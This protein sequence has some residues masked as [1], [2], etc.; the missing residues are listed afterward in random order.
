MVLH[1]LV[2]VCEVMGANCVNT[3]AEGIKT[4]VEL[5]FESDVLT[6]ICSNLA[7]HRMTKVAMA[8]LLPTKLAQSSFKIQVD[9]LEY[10]GVPGREV[11]SKILSIMDWAAHDPFRAATHNKGI[12]NGIDSVAI[13]TGQDWRAI[14]SAAHTNCLQN[15]SGGIFNSFWIEDAHGEKVDAACELTAPSYFCGSMELPMAVATVGGAIGSN[16]TYRKSLRI[17]GNPNSKR[18]AGIL[19]SVGLAQNF[20]AVRA[21]VTEGIQR[22]HMSLHARNIAMQAGSPL[23]LVTEVAEYLR[24]TQR[25]SVDVAKGSGNLS[26]LT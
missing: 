9:S 2:D 25:M 8:M 10:K 14:E 15:E 13:A 4:R 26:M 20:A 18:L 21:L 1:I 12:M 16:P 23:H 17:M 24:H 5:I 6:C 7:M 3:I 22:G 11:A 19:V